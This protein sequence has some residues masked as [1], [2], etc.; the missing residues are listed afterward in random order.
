[1]EDMAR[2]RV[3]AHIEL[4]PIPRGKGHDHY[5]SGIMPNHFFEGAE[6]S[7]IGKVEFT[8]QNSLAFGSSSEALVTFLWP[9][10][11]PAMKPGLRWRLQEGSTH[12]GNGVILEVLHGG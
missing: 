1:M 5:L 9:P 7:T 2:I 8:G 12:V 3:R 11:W 4:L 10:N 6:G